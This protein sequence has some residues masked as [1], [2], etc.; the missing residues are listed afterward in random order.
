MIVCIITKLNEFECD[1]AHIIPY[2][3]CD[4]YAPEFIYDIRNGL[5]L[6]KNIHA[7]FDKFY[8]TFDIYDIIYD[9][10]TGQYASRLIIYPNHR[11]MSINV[12]KDQYVVI[13]IEN[14]PFLYTHYQLFI[15]YH[16]DLNIN[17]D[18]FYQ[19]IITED[20]AFKY[21]CTHT[22]P[23]NHILNKTVKQFLY[24]YGLIKLHNNNT[25]YFVNAII[26]NK[27]RHDKNYY[28]VW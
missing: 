2:K 18:K 20:R 22:L 19:E 1:A 8:W 26:K 11:N 14:Y 12:F 25:D 6:S 5:F 21:L 15:S 23:I 3:I 7:L 27:T 10:T 9:A 13:P 24:S 17:I 28:L 4:K 16:Y